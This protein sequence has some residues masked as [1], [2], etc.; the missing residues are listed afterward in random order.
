MGTARIALESAT[1]LQCPSIAVLPLFFTRYSRAVVAD[2]NRDLRQ[3]SC[4]L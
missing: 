3:Y 2:K 1:S 4:G